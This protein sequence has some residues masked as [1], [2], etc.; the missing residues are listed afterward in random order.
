[1]WTLSPVGA[2]LTRYTPQAEASRG[3]RLFDQTLIAELTGLDVANASLYD[4]GRAVG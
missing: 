4:D 2:S 1:V 3:R